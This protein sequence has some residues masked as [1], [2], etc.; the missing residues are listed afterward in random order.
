[1]KILLLAVATLVGATTVAMATPT[2]L[3]TNASLD[4]A[5]QFF[6]ARATLT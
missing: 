3:I 4:G 2:N 5:N 1:M 6:T